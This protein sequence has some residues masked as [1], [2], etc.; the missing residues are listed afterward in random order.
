MLRIRGLADRFTGQDEADKHAE[1]GLAINLLL[2]GVSMAVTTI[3]C[4]V[5]ALAQS[6]EVGKSNIESFLALVDDLWVGTTSA[7]PVEQKLDEL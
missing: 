3:V 5:N 2:A 1:V 4:E 6:T 7:R